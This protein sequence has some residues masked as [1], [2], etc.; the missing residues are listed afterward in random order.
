[1]ILSYEK[2]FIFLKTKK[3]AGTSIE[4]ALSKYCGDKDIITPI[5]WADEKIR[6]EY[7]YRGPQNYLLPISKYSL[8]DFGKLIKHRNKKKNFYN[9]I[10]ASEVKVKVD[11]EIWENSYKFAFERNP[12][13]RL[14]SM[15]FF[16]YRSD[17][18]P[19]ITDLL[20]D[21]ILRAKNGGWRVY[22]INNEIAVDKVF[23]YEDLNDALTEIANRIGINEEI[24]LPFAKQ[25][26]RKKSSRPEDILSQSDLDKIR[27]AFSQ[28]IEL[29]G[30]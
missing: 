13:E 20:D 15:Y 4:I 2:K 30:Y 16:R 7:K 25:E 24:I 22:T 18:R 14:I 10:T 5:D 9:H 23:K 21:L 8:R 27:N 26:H 12:F 11:P 1:M 17:N 3:T 6:S 28:E 29:F 19:P